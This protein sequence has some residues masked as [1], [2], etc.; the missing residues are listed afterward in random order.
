MASEAGADCSN[1]EFAGLKVVPVDVTVYAVGD[2]VTPF[3]VMLVKAEAHAE[4]EG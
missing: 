4:D 1:D 2:I 3:T